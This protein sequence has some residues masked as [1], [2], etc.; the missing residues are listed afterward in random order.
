MKQLLILPIF[1]LLLLVA[2][3]MPASAQN[4]EQQQRLHVADSVLKVRESAEAVTKRHLKE[5]ERELK[6]AENR[7]K[8][9][10][11]AHKIA[12]DAASDA[13]KAY[14]LEQKAIKARSKADK[15][16]AETLQ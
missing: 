10:K 9:A 5:A 7:Y 6:I 8:E 4:M 14:K 12:S 13:K 3:V 11:N 16:S 2:G 15:Q 1:L